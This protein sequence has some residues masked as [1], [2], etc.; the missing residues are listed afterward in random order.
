MK[1]STSAE[2]SSSSF[3]CRAM[4]S[5]CCFICFVAS[6]LLPWSGL[7][8]SC[9]LSLPS[10]VFLYWR[11]SFSN[12]FCNCDSSPTAI[13]DSPLSSLSSWSRPTRFITSSW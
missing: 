13:L 11:F 4:S 7:M 9:T 3:F 10:W 12:C 2:M 5:S 8:D 1:R 6:F